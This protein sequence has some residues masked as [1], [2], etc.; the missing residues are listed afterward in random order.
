MR[1][2]EEHYFSDMAM[3][4]AM[5]PESQEDQKPAKR[6]NIL[7]GKIFIKGGRWLLQMLSKLEPPD[8]TPPRQGI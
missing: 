5:G 4:P 8:S 3:G 2:D 1:D 6:R 7:K